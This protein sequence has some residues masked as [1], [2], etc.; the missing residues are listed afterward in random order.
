[1]KLRYSPTSPYVRKVVITATEL[2][3]NDKIE[4]IATDPWA[5]DTNLRTDNPLSKVPCLITDDGEAIYDSPVIC[6]YLNAV[7]KGSLFPTD[8]KA[9]FKTLTLAATGDGMTDAGVLLI[10][11]NVRRP[12]ELKWEWWD[13]RQRTNIY[14]A[15]DVIEGA[16]GGLV[17]EGPL[18][19]AEI[20]IGAGLGWLDFRFPDLAWRDSRPGLAKWFEAISKRP[21]FVTSAPPKS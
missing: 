11:E 9:R 21:S 7:A 5:A 14:C 18:T 10:A 1:M 13:Q 19:I 16:I 15:M 17:S 20:T 6:E 2:G 3:L 12:K 4:R 8:I